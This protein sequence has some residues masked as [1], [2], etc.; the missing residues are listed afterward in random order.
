MS[1]Y[2]CDYQKWWTSLK[3]FYL[4][5]AVWRKSYKN[6]L[7]NPA[8]YICKMN[9]YSLMW[10]H[11]NLSPSCWK[12]YQKIGD[13]TRFKIR[14]DLIPM[15]VSPT[16]GKSKIV[17]IVFQIT[18]QVGLLRSMGKTYHINWNAFFPRSKS[19][20]KNI[21][22]VTFFSSYLHLYGSNHCIQNFPFCA[23][24]IYFLTCALSEIMACFKGSLYNLSSILPA[25]SYF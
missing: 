3:T 21:T 23:H 12:E 8:F 20:R 5:L 4:P 1:H 18:P 6:S 16:L 17:P 10:L 7:M 15:T 11:T 14:S 25:T 22:L 24:L 9:L 19:S 2:W 13:N